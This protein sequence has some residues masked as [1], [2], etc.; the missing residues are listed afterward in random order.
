MHLAKL[1]PDLTCSVRV[2]LDRRTIKTISL[3][4]EY[5]ALNLT[6][7]CGDDNSYIN[8]MFTA[9]YAKYFRFGTSYI[10]IVNKNTSEVGSGASF[11]RCI[12]F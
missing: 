11:A 3:F 1:V 5:L 4:S 7:I 10:S 8:V 12:L 6:F 2:N 9:N